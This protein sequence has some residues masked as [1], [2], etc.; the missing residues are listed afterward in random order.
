MVVEDLCDC[1]W[2]L[3]YT[4]YLQDDSMKALIHHT[5]ATYAKS[6]EYAD[7]LLY[8]QCSL[9]IRPTC[10]RASI[11]TESSEW[12]KPLLSSSRQFW[13]R[14]TGLRAC[15]TRPRISTHSSICTLGKNSKRQR[16][17]N[18]A[19]PS[20]TAKHARSRLRSHMSPLL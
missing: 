20:E 4:A 18:P 14:W 6:D 2:V 19:S 1:F 15:R 9:Y 12:V 16:F 11:L 13:T 10:V 17:G 5:L 3:H 8:V 7:L